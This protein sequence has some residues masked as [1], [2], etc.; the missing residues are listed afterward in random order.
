MGSVLV[1]SLVLTILAYMAFIQYGQDYQSYLVL[2]MLIPAMIMAFI[3]FQL[4]S[5]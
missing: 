4:T 2:A 1:G 3:S 5:G